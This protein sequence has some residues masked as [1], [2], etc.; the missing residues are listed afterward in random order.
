MAGRL[1]P[2][3][4]MTQE[5]P[6]PRTL[7]SGSRRARF[8]SRNAAAVFISAVDHQRCAERRVTPWNEA[9]PRLDS[10]RLLNA[11]VVPAPRCEEGDGYS[12][13][14]DACWRT[15][16]C[17]G[18]RA[19]TLNERMSHPRIPLASNTRPVAVLRRAARS[20]LPRDRIRASAAG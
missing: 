10:R 4:R 15:A 20:L 6:D 16:S 5:T 19:T 2:G 3:V 7:A 17:S 12:H 9:M 11:R 14:C 1:E 18:L 8:C 13:R